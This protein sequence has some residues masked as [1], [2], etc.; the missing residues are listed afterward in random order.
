MT[1]LVMD[2]SKVRAI[3]Y[4]LDGTVYDDN[5]HFALY[6]REIQA[7]LD[8][9]VHADFLR[10]YEAVAGGRHPALRVGSFYDVERDLILLPR[11]GR[12]VRAL[13]WEGAEV[14][15]VVRQQLYPGTVEP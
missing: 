9:E 11:G 14:P 5:R 12:V 13:H 7:H 15:P 4:D 3:V 2:I 8:P 6:A 10:D 1:R